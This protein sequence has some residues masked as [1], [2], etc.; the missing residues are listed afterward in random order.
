[1]IEKNVD[2]NVQHQEKQTKLS[3]CLSISCQSNMAIVTEIQCV[4]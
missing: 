4:L 1:M 3:E 2:W